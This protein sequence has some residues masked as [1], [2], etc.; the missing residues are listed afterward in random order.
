MPSEVDEIKLECFIPNPKIHLMMRNSWFEMHKFE[1]D[2]P[3][4]SKWIRSC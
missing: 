1:S 4:D 3:V 2:D